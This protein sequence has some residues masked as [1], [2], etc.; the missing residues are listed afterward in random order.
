MPSKLVLD[1]CALLWLATG[2]GKLSP[3]ALSAIDD[4]EVVLVSA[5]S[6]WEIGM[7]EHKKQLELPLP[8][9]KWFERAVEAHGLAVADLSLDIL[10][11]AN[12][13]PWH[14]RDPADRFIIATAI[15]EQC[16]VVTADGRFNQYDIEILN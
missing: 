16:P 13:L 4:A 3:E 6:L 2:G 5:I 7:K 15:L 1:T 11:G 9:S 10:A 12:E 8:P 14:H